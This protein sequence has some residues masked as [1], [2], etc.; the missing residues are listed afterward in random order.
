MSLFNK[1]DGWSW[2][3]FIT[4]GLLLFE[5]IFLD[6]GML[7][8]LFFSALFIYIG[9]KYYHKFIGKIVFWVSLVNA[10]I[11]IFHTLAFRWLVFSVII[12]FFIQYVKSKKTQSN[13]KVEEM[14][15][16]EETSSTILRK[17]PYFQNKLIGRQ[18]TPQAIYEWED[19]NVQGFVGEVIIDLSQTVFPKGEA[20]VFVRHFF[21][22]VQVLVPY[23]MEVSVHSSMVVG[24]YEIFDQVNERVLNESIVYQT[25]DYAKAE[26]KLKIVSSMFA[27]HIEVK[28]V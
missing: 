5:I 22:N 8:F 27:G 2:I 17:K 9:K 1:Y 13:I 12:Y 26:Q 16:S 28:R 20:L 19:V 10:V 15:K 25:A 4:V 6:G 23:D 24:T 3:F 21:G 18:S 7:Y 11:A 14:K